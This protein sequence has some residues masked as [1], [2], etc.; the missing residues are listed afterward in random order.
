MFEKFL[1]LKGFLRLGKGSNQ[2]SRL[3]VSELK[4]ENLPIS[5]A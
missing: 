3:G 5:G 4:S 2:V 1:P